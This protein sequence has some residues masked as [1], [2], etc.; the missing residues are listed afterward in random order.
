MQASHSSVDDACS[1][2]EPG[3][4]EPQATGLG[5]PGSSE[6]LLA[7][8]DRR[9]VVS[10]RPVDQFAQ[11]RPTCQVGQVS[12]V[13]SRAVGSRDLAPPR[14]ALPRSDP[15]G[16]PRDRMACEGGAR[17]HFGRNTFCRTKAGS[18]Q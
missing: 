7:C 1:Q 15:P 13:V 14:R 8:G 17:L 9:R 3:R 18:S 12:R 11:D 2:R 10:A 5:S 6:M 4:P 16:S